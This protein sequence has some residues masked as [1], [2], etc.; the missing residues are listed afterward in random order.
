V[1]A[2]TLRVCNMNT[3]EISREAFVSPATIVRFSKKMGFTGFEQFKRELYAE[4]ISNDGKNISIDADFPFEED[5]PYEDIFQRM[6]DLEKK[7]LQE[8]KE[9]I[10]LDKWDHIISDM[11]TCKSIDIYGEGISFATANNFKINME[12]IGYNVFMESDRARQTNRCVSLFPDHFN[13][14]LSYSGELEIT[15]AIAKLLQLNNL[16]SLSI[17]SERANRLMQYTTHHLPIARM[18]GRI[19]S[20]GISN[21]CSSIS[22]SF[23]LDMIYAS[24]F[25]KNYQENRE[26]IRKNVILQNTYL[27]K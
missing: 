7:A 15:L 26:R 27:V 24:I 2:N 20:G 17:T 11:A 1:L 22:F 3:R 8:T 9:L 21:M 4:W 5:T 19:T 10:P 6:V 23:V 25:K 12:R 14:L 16:K 18:E 13:L